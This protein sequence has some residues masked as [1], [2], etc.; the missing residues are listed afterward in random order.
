MKTTLSLLKTMPVAGL[1]CTAVLLLCMPVRLRALS[2]GEAD[3][4]QVYRD[5]IRWSSN[6]VQKSEWLERAA[7]YSLRVGDTASLLSFKIDQAYLRFSSG[8]YVE[9]FDSLILIEKKISD[10]LLVPS[11]LATDAVYKPFVKHTKDDSVWVDMH[12]AAGIS[13]AE[14]EIYLNEFAEATD[15][16]N[17]IMTL[18]VQDTTG[19][20][21]VRCLNALGAICAHRAM[22]DMA[23]KYFLQALELG[24]AMMDT[25]SL[26]SFY[27]NLAAIYAVKGDGNATLKYALES[28]RILEKAGLYGEHYIYALYYVG[29]AYRTLGQDGLALAQLK[30]ALKEAEENQYGHLALYV[31][32]DLINT[33]L[34]QRHLEEAKA[35]ALQNLRQAREV[36]NQRAEERTLLYLAQIAEDQKDYEQSM[37]YIDTAFGVSKSLARFDQDMQMDYLQ[38]KFDSYRQEQEHARSIQELELAHSKLETRNL[39]ILVFCIA[40]LLLAI[41]IVVIYRRFVAQRR[42]NRLI[43]MRLDENESISQD[44]MEDLQQEY[45]RALSDRDKELASQAL[46]YAKIEGLVETLGEKLRAMRTLFD[47]KAKEKMYVAEMEQLLKEF[48]PDKNWNEFELYFKRVDNEFFEKLE[49]R[50]PDLTPN[51]KRLCA[52]IRLNLNSKEIADMTSRTFRSVNTAKTRLKKKLGVNPDMSLYDFLINL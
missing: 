38:R 39:W 28:S 34:S 32:S 52:L 30:K 5:S 31:R 18:H 7:V 4:L 41:A 19:I 37:Y 2:P 49:K 40:G 8:N 21:A 33:L 47:L 22:F 16:I 12:V 6:N 36:G 9:A 46:Y 20:I 42:L 1:L 24:K 14:L 35:Y 11:F 51:E 27:E 15:I 50:F 43:R 48:T 17:R 44:R 29:I 3:T 13:L 45:G 23:E 10:H 26:A 25:G